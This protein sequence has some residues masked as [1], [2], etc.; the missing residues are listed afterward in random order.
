MKK[1]I[2][3]KELKDNIKYAVDLLCSTVKSTLGPSGNNTI[4]NDANYTPFI[5]NDGVT[6]AKSIEE[7]NMIINTILYL[8]KEAEIKTY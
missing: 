2:K 6:I 4:I 8:I 7:E 1:I 3:N 5:T